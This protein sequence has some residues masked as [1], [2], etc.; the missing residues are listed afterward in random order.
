MND[1]S[2]SSTYN[3]DVHLIDWVV[4]LKGA[5]KNK[6]LVSL[7]I[8]SEKPTVL[9]VQQTGL[10]HV[11]HLTAGLTDFGLLKAHP[12]TRTPAENSEGTRTDLTDK[13]HSPVISLDRTSILWLLQYYQMSHPD[14]T[15]HSLP[16]FSLVCRKKEKRHVIKWK[17]LQFQV[18][19][20]E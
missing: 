13:K 17:L 15:L 4:L 16:Y 8:K 7:K 12:H 9:Q 1:F 3:N 11:L 2:Q 20:W 10:A 6:T 19:W 14:L 5:F 18:H